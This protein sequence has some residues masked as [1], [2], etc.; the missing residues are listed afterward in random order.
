MNLCKAVILFQCVFSSRF[1]YTIVMIV[2]QWMSRLVW[3]FF[4]PKSAL[5]VSDKKIS[6]LVI[7]YAAN[8]ISIVWFGI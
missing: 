1:F 3:G 6:Q 7:G 2:P 5:I 8:D 4:S